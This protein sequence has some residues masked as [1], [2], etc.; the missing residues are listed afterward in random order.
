MSGLAVGSRNNVPV[1]VALSR[2][3][4][5]LGPRPTSPEI[6]VAPALMTTSAPD[7]P[8]TANWPAAPSPKNGFG[9]GQH[10]GG[11]EEQHPV[12]LKSTP[13][14]SAKSVTV[15]VMHLSPTQF[16]GT[17]THTSHAPEATSE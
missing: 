10:P 17:V 5:S 9:G 16:A 15:I 7:R 6:R 1:M 3:P 12:K 2:S 4:V 11:G 13:L 14:F 8:S